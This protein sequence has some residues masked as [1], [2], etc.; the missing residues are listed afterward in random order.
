MFC[1][2]KRHAKSKAVALALTMRYVTT[3]M[4]I[5]LICLNNLDERFKRA[6]A[7]DIQTARQNK[8]A[9]HDLRKF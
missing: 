6:T 4:N 9:P 7:H 5:K 2:A 3:T 8:P 1:L